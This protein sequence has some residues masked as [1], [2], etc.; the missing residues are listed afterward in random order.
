MY[1][2]QRVAQ[3]NLSNMRLSVVKI[4]GSQD[5]VGKKRADHRTEDACFC[6]MTEIWLVRRAGFAAA[7][8]ARKPQTKL[9]ALQSRFVITLLAHQR[10][11]PD[12]IADSHAFPASVAVRR[13]VGNTW[14]NNWY[15]LIFHQ[16][17]PYTFNRINNAELSP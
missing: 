1:G 11:I 6:L 2:A 14:G 15:K 7:L 3:R 9:P 5:E 17:K 10:V 8:G 4:N 13:S 12:I 16:L